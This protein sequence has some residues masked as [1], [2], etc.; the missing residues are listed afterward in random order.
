M[1]KFK[2]PHSK[3]KRTTVD[4]PYVWENRMYLNPVFYNEV[5]KNPQMVQAP[6]Y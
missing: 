5:Y 6:G 3:N 2:V 4:A 1:Q